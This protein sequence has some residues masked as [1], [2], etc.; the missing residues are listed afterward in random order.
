MEAAL[1][2]HYPQTRR[3][4]I[5]RKLMAASSAELIRA[6][7][8]SEAVSAAR[9]ELVVTLRAEMKIALHMRCASRAPR[10]QGRAKQ[11]VENRA[12]AA[13]HDE[14]DQHPEA[15]THCPPWRILAH[16]A[17]HQEIKRGHQ[18]PGNI[19]VDAQAE[20]RHMVLRLW[21]D[22]PEVVLNQHEDGGRHRHRPQRNHP[23]I[24]VGIYKLW[25]THKTI[26]LSEGYSQ[27]KQSIIAIS[28]DGGRNLEVAG[29]FQG[30]LL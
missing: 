20:G 21:E 9:A 12:D 24:F 5:V 27:I 8:C 29:Y 6:A 1:L 25:I 10:N 3:H 17:H 28:I 13:G 14:A 22:K 23:C 16:E 30:A 15:G 26:P 19:Q 4:G 7:N 2:G 11:K 18:S